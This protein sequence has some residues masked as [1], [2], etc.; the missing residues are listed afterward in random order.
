M[1]G[2]GRQNIGSAAAAESE[3][4]IVPKAGSPTETDDMDQVRAFINAII[5]AMIER[6][7]RD[8]TSEDQLKAVFRKSEPLKGELTP[9]NMRPKTLRAY[10][11]L[12]GFAEMARSYLPR[13]IR[14]SPLNLVQTIHISCIEAALR[15]LDICRDA[16]KFGDTPL[17]WLPFLDHAL[18][19]IEG[20]ASPGNEPLS[21]V[22]DASDGRIDRTA[23][24]SVPAG[25]A[26]KMDLVVQDLGSAATTAEPDSMHSSASSVVPE[27]V[28][29]HPPASSHLRLLVLA[30]TILV[31]SFGAIMISRAP[32]RLP[33][34][35]TPPAVEGTWPTTEDNSAPSIVG[36]PIAAMIDP[37]KLIG[38]NAGSDQSNV[39]SILTSKI[40]PRLQEATR[41]RAEGNNA[42]ADR[43]AQTVVDEWSR[44]RTL[45]NKNEA[46]AHRQLGAS[47]YS[48]NNYDGSIAEYKMAIDID[49]TPADYNERGL[50]YHA[51]R[52]L[53]NALANYS[54][55]IR[56]DP[57]KFSWPYNNRGNVYL[58]QVPPEPDIAI[59]NYNTALKIDP[60]LA[61]ALNNRG[62]AYKLKGDYDA[63]ILDYNRAIAIN[64]DYAFPHNG[65]GGAYY[66]K[67][68][69]RQAIV[70]YNE[71]IR[72]NHNYIEAWISRGFAYFV[73]KD[74][75][76]A[77]EDLSEAIKI[78]SRTPNFDKT[79][80]ARAY[81]GRGS[82]YNI[83]MSLKQ[84]VAD[85]DDAIRLDPT[86]ALA[87][88]GRGSAYGTMRKYTA[89][90]EDFK[91]AVRRDRAFVPTYMMRGGIYLSKGEPGPAIEDF[92][93]IVRLAPNEPW[94]YLGRG[95]ARAAQ[96]DV[97]GSIADFSD[98]E[99]LSQEP[100]SSG[101]AK[102]MKFL[103]TND[104][105]RAIEAI[106]PLFSEPERN[107]L[108]SLGGA[109]RIRGTIY[110]ANEDFDRAI[111][112]FSQALSIYPADPALYM[113]RG[114]AYDK[115][116]EPEKAIADYGS[117]IEHD[118]TNVSAYLARGNSYQGSRDYEHA[119]QDYERVVNL[120]PSDRQ[121][122]I[123]YVDLGQIHFESDPDRAIEDYGKAIKTAV[124]PLNL[125]A[126]YNRATLFE[127]RNDYS[128]AIDD[129][130]ELLKIA[131]GSTGVYGARG[132]AYR[133]I[134]NFDESLSDYTVQLAKN[135][136]DARAYDNRGDTYYA[137][138]QYGRAIADYSM[139]IAADPKF[140]YAYVDRGKAHEA[141]RAYDLAINDYAEAI[142]RDPTSTMAA[143]R[144]Y[145]ARMH[146]RS[147]SAGKEL[148]ANA[149]MLNRSD[150][151]YPVVELFLGRRAADA[152]LAGAGD[153]RCEI[154]FYVAKWQMLQGN[155]QSAI[156]ML[157]EALA[158][159][160]K[161]DI[162]YYDARIELRG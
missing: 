114:E 69:I 3:S 46:E 34:K 116:S 54:E 23:G 139:A 159:C 151:L 82:A 92:A 161:A 36:G 7:A 78:I 38:P 132:R 72:I 12:F 97:A 22:G 65:L 76:S 25:D 128:R 147:N 129:Y 144:L 11:R 30:A 150:P 109:Y 35:M 152:V 9:G 18:A 145:I 57:D 47:A 98:T 121:L 103:L 77:I 135:R 83:T 143:L 70:S 106:A 64:K 87:Y 49:A 90:F 2:T 74:F 146:E 62:N 32:S 134:G 117:A 149:K 29:T 56:R 55:A 115:K 50:A 120:R 157:N 131:P 71:A 21:A 95:L 28:R 118:P 89:A 126:Y 17:S 84:A 31:M 73:A 112:D 44:A 141:Q 14:S 10:E 4:I 104:Y 45:T 1:S 107:N 79:L 81:A 58:E 19:A 43:L 137:S 37:K 91:E 27:I 96:N 130:S 26:S 85:F 125:R 33:R 102:A 24:G 51:K 42:E 133:A 154:L 75:K 66:E 41:L 80:A 160:S 142:K 16:P 119:V 111:K 94:G 99:R 100:F 93:E 105:D 140:V 67:G 122:A 123:A 136:Y 39:S 53:A 40:D 48:F 68:D 60:Q 61:S 59:S 162:P 127:N 13:E 86:A 113:A 153:D 124:V 20:K 5:D 8:N 6:A 110:V 156:R 155:D 158:S 148:D 138:G 63:A 52:D 88:A 15:H 101:I 108:V